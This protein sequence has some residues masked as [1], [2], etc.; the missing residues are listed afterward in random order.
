MKL[1]QLPLNILGVAVFATLAAS[2]LAALASPDTD[3]G[4]TPRASSVP[5]S[6]I[7]SSFSTF[8]GSDANADALVSG[9]RSGSEITL[10][11]SVTNA[12]GTTS[13]TPVTIQPATGPLGY[14]EVKI[15]LSL[16]EA[17]LAAQGITDPTA[18]EI[19]AALNGGTLTLA[20]GT[21]VD[22]QGT[23]A[24]RASGEGWGQI[25]NALGFKLGDLMRSP[26]AA[27][28]VANAN[29]RGNG[30]ADIKVE[31]VSFAQGRMVDHPTAMAH[32]DRPERPVR[33]ER[34]E[35][36]ERPQIPDHPTHVG[37]PGG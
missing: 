17:S 11:Q 25:A 13:T 33:P 14:G 31:K 12:D 2:P 4:S 1:R 30:H 27:L 23:L 34:P 9:L 19:A 28:A 24:A 5:G 35:I 29:A 22:L 32:V 7:A 37:R 8:A 3:V 10:D 21:T 36:P 16:A 20:D 26:K 18:E 15:A 6:S